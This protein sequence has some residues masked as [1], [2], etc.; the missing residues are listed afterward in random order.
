MR[1]NVQMKFKHLLA[2]VPLTL[3]GMWVVTCDGG[4]SESP[5]EWNVRLSGTGSRCSGWLEI[6]HIGKQKRICTDHW[7][8][9]NAELACKQLGCGFPFGM[10]EPYPKQPEKQE[11]HIL[12]C[13]G[14]ETAL[15]DCVWQES[16]CTSHVALVCQD[17]MEISTAS[18]PTT[19]PLVTFSKSTDAPR[20]R[21]EDGT[22]LCSRAVEP[23]FGEHWEMVCLNM[24]RWWSRLVP[25]DCQGADCE[26]AVGLKDLER[27]NSLPVHWSKVQCEQKHLSLDCLSMTKECLNITMLKCS[28]QISKPRVSN[29]ETVLGILLG[30]ILTAV[31]LVICVPP[32]YKKLVNK[33]SKKRQ[34]QWIGPSGMNQN[35]SFHRNSSIAFQPHPENHKI[36][37]ENNYPALKKNSSL[38]PYAALEGATNRSSNPT[39]NSSDS[40]YDLCSA[41]QV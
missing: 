26:A 37:E 2:F 33:Y 13:K 31:L 12:D 36:Q 8:R 1:R 5:E 18:D 9:Q 15:E 24:Q 34:H 29:T 22:T 35:V 32:T 41:Q 20:I 23:N 4:Q 40:D 38:S 10:L 25:R 3:V 11:T 6:Y 30:L 16:N 27:K 19:V 14:N 28:D 39:D 7:T 17:P 21:L